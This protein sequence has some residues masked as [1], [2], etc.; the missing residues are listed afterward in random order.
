LR[1]SLL[2]RLLATSVLIA[3]CSIAATAWLAVQTTTRAIQEAQGQALSDDAK[4]YDSL[5]GYAA[6]HSAWAGVGPTVTR[7]AARTGRRITLTTADR[8][9]IAR[10]STTAEQ[11]PQS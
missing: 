9:P 8:T 7:L 10:S 6:T 1:R 4:I 5:V 2:I 3:L 11:L